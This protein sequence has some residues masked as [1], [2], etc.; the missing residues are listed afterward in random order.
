M[1]LGRT[2]GIR[3]DQGVRFQLK[4]TLCI[5]LYVLLLYFNAIFDIFMNLK[6]ANLTW[7]KVSALFY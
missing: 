7:M 6:K 4:Q 3:K 1:R 5:V 2:D